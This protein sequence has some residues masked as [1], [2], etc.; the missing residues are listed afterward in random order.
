[1]IFVQPTHR[2]KI[3]AGPDKVYIEPHQLE[4]SSLRYL[5]CFPV[6]M[7][8]APVHSQN[9]PWELPRIPDRELASDDPNTVAISRKNNDQE[10]KQTVYVGV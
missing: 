8:S 1:M 7:R 3:C 4:P 2:S 10:L 5:T 6:C 9:S